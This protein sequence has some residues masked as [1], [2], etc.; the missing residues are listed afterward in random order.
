MAALAAL[1]CVAGAAQA[2]PPLKI[3]GPWEVHSI[4]PA[5]NGVLFTRLQVAESLVD[6]DTNSVLRPGLAES[7]KVSADQ[8]SWRFV[9][10]KGAQ[11]HDG[12]PVTAEAV[13]Q[14]LEIALKKPG[15][16]KTAPIKRFVAQKGDVIVELN[17]PFA[18][19]PAVL[20]HASAQIL[21]PS[22]YAADGSVKQV[23]ATGPYRITQLSQPQAVQTAR[24]DKWWGKA[25]E[26]G[27]VSYLS[28]GRG[29]TRALMAESGQSDI[30]FGLD[31]VSL[32]RVR[33]KGTVQIV[34]VTLPRTILVK[35]NA[36]Q[37]ILKDVSIRQA[38]S[39]SI[40][41]AGL[42]RA[43]LRDPEMAAVQLFP[44]TMSDWHR[45]DVSPLK[46]D[47][48]KAAELLAAAGWKA[49]ADGILM[50]DGKRFELALRTYPD[51]PELPPIATAI[52]DQLRKVGI[53]VQVKI[54]NSSEIPAGHR[55]GTLELGLAARNFA[56][57][58]DPLITLIDDY[59][60]KGGDWGAMNWSRPVVT[61]ALQRLA[62]DPGAN[63]ARAHRAQVIN[64]LQNE[65]PVI[66]VAWYRQS[67]AV[68]KKLEGV[69][70]DP[71]ERS[72]LLTDM[73][74]RK[75]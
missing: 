61:T 70:L 72:Y 49:G 19:L 21:A 22:S 69:A 62:I 36:G 20:A 15:V 29:E 6:A 40:D 30:T 18:P 12:S 27:E 46:Y 56:L 17:K 4:D 43:L 52:Q 37:E 50:R 24:F 13:V 63:E 65:L 60:D 54:V 33:Q 31:P 25:P 16:M 9:L 74:W 48:K 44:P 71:L 8:L 5:S 39:L 64:V 1:W 57:V 53:A 32:G 3:V 2:A 23:I 73:R 55:D 14:A 11:F 35:V 45:N 68:S 66:P 75:Q 7:W 10:R 42:T 34:S 51:R 28:V 38:L 59:G 67:A 41:R 47:P 26:I 58:P